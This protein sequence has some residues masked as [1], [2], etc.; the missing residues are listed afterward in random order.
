MDNVKV[1][2]SNM[3]LLRIVAMLMIVI[4]HTF[5][6][7][8][9]YYQESAPLFASLTVVLH[10]GVILFVLISGYFGIKPSVKGFLRL[11]CV[12]IFYD[13]VLYVVFVG[14]GEQTLSWK[15]AIKCLLPMSCHRGDYW[16][17]REYMILYLCSPLINQVRMRYKAVGGG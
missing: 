10:I 8:L 5:Y 9:Q 11:Y 6:Y 16:F 17:I 12:V 14:I 3:E 7:R 1:R 4:Y 2:E 15:E 13:L